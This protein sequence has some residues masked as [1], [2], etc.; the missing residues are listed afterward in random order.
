MALVLIS[1]TLAK[2]VASGLKMKTFVSRPVLSSTRL[3]VS[4][5]PAFAWMV[6]V[7][8]SP[9][10]KLPPAVTPLN[11]DVLSPSMT[12]STTTAVMLYPPVSFAPESKTTMV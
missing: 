12:S 4:S 1:T 5:S 9:I 10:V 2:S 8:M 7:S 11:S 3:K 6:K